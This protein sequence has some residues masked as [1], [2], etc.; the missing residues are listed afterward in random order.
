MIMIILKIFN[1]GL[2]KIILEKLIRE[3]QT[4][5]KMDKMEVANIYYK[6]YARCK[7]G[8]VEW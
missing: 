1:A 6:D 2:I 7:D 3:V 8:E 4:P 5:R